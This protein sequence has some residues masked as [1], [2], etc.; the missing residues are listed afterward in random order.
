MIL[1][2]IFVPSLDKTYDFQLNENIKIKLIVEEIVEM[3]GQHE[4]STIV[5]SVDELELCSKTNGFVLDKNKSLLGSKV[6]T[7]DSLILI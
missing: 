5:G 2:D 4:H 7:G 6:N 3:I 1:V